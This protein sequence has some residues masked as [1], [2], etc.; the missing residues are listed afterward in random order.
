MLTTPKGACSQIP[1]QQ[2]LLSGWTMNR[3]LF[4]VRILTLDARSRLLR[5]RIRCL[6]YGG[7]RGAHNHHDAMRAGRHTIRRLPA[8]RRRVTGRRGIW[9]LTIRPLY[10]LVRL[11]AL[12]IRGL[13]LRLRAL[14]C[15]LVRLHTLI[16]LRVLPGLVARIG[17]LYALSGICRT[18]HV[19]GRLRKCRKRAAQGCREN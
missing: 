17:L 18:I 6:R 4:Q 16:E 3:P 19:A 1:S 12:P 14:L 7:S 2:S 10:T 9:R 8:S 15:N 5:Y 13:L 11:R